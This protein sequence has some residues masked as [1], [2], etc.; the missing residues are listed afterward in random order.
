MRAPE[1]YAPQFGGHCLMSLARG[2]LSD[3]KP[4]L[5]VIEGAKL[6]FFYSSANRD[7]FLMARAGAIETAL[8][9]WPELS[10]ELSGIGSEMSAGGAMASLDEAEPVAIAAKDVPAH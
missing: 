2:Y 1:T 3:G 6:Y 9:H 4:R 5:Y 8:V 7:A 10:T